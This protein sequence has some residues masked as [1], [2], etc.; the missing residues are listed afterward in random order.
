M[1]EVVVLG[2]GLPQRTVEE[3][4]TRHTVRCLTRDQLGTEPGRQA[5]ARAEGAVVIGQIPVTEEF[6]DAAPA[7]KVVSLRAVGYD[8]VDLEA[9][10]RRGVMVCN[11][12]SVLDDAVADLAVL[13][14][15]GI[16]RRLGEMLDSGKGSWPRTGRRPDLG[17]DVRGKVLGV[18]GMGRIGRRVAHTC[19]A[20]FGMKVL[21]H[22]RS[23][24]VSGSETVEATWVGLEE[25]LVRSDFVTVHLPLTAE[26]RHIVGEKELALMKRGS[27][28]VNTSRGAVVDEAA[29]VAALRSGH[30]AGAGLD[31]LATE[32]PETTNPLLHMPNVMITPHM[33]S[34]TEETRHAMAEVAKQNLMNALAGRDPIARVV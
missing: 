20:G 32:P 8:K 5:L 15:V 34:A 24:P 3:I 1:A 12:P 22:T 29:L 19:A 6:L 31:V 23:G 11:T 13:L 10:R 25:L 28:L 26:T 27:Y 17:T 9:C 21:Y 33:G 30:I 7:L 16:A 14:I 2:T 18:L 4:K